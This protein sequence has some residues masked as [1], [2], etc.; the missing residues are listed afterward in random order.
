MKNLNDAE[1]KK[2]RAKITDLQLEDLNE[3]GIASGA[4]GSIKYN[5]ELKPKVVWL[6][7]TEAASTIP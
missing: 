2:C 1:T 6:L 4:Y 7:W 5:M 3:N